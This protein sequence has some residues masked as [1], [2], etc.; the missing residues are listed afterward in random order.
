MKITTKQSIGHDQTFVNGPLSM[1][2][3]QENHPQIEAP[4]LDRITAWVQKKDARF[5]SEL[6]ESIT[7]L[8]L[9]ILR[10]INGSKNT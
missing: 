1:G 4:L 6:T 2:R 8:A 7:I 9:L 3:P 5:S 10:K